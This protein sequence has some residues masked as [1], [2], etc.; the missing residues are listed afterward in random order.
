VAESE[1]IIFHVFDACA[2]L[3]CVTLVG[4]HCRGWLSPQSRSIAC[5]FVA[6]LLCLLIGLGAPSRRRVLLNLPEL[7]E[8]EAE[9]EACDEGTAALWTGLLFVV[10]GLLDEHISAAS[11]LLLGQVLGFQHLALDFL[12]PRPECGARAG[13]GGVLLGLRPVWA[14]ALLLWALAGVLAVGRLRLDEAR[15]QEELVAAY[16]EA[17]SNGI[18]SCLR[19]EGGETNFTQTRLERLFQ[20]I[21]HECRDF[22]KLLVAMDKARRKK[23]W[24]MQGECGRFWSSAWLRLSAHLGDVLVRCGETLQHKEDNFLEAAE[25]D[26]DGF[27]QD[28]AGWLEQSVMLQD[29]RRN[30]GRNSTRNSRGSLESGASFRSCD[31]Q[32]HS[33]NAGFRLEYRVGEWDF[34]ALR[35]EEE[36]HHVLQL[37]GFDLLKGFVALPRVPLGAFLE[38]LEEQY[39]ASNPYHSHVHGA[40][41]TSA[42]FF[43][44]RTSQMWEFAELSDSARVAMLLAALGH[45]VGHGGRNNLFLIGSGDVLALNYNDRSVLENYHAATLS[46]LLKQEHGEST[47]RGLLLDGFTFADQTKA[48]QLMLMLILS[49]DS[50]KHLE[51]LS[52][53]RV[54]LGAEA[55]NPLGDTSD[56]QQALSMLFRAAD[57]GHSAK[58][59]RLHENWSRRVV[60]EF[61]AQ[62]DEERRL[63]L[64]VSPL[65]DREGFVL[66]TAQVG[67]LQYIALPTWKELVR[68]EQAV[69]SLVRPATPASAKGL[70]DAKPHFSLAVTRVVGPGR[71]SP[72]KDCLGEDT[73]ASRVS[74][75]SFDDGTGNNFSS[76]CS[77]RRHF[78]GLPNVLVSCSE[79]GQASR[80]PPKPRQS[81]LRGGLRDGLRDRSRSPSPSP[82]PVCERLHI[83]DT[84]LAQCESNCQTWK[85][86]V[87]VDGVDE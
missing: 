18:E 10:V 25:A 19:A 71:E 85:N 84:C 11:Y 34:D 40:D 50:Q 56:M 53:F 87:V 44:V 75:R 64:P 23:P 66:A 47:E 63:G 82:M 54:R 48:R 37:I 55:F 74:R 4:L 61:H 15:K 26:Q 13:P 76:E 6:W 3:I 41:M 22:H 28:V 42:F 62:G 59:W 20:E 24:L 52:A 30:M 65:C 8:A 73:I 38:R 5:A 78:E 36:Q 32:F 35:T 81:G 79:A 57:I 7:P 58:E 60:Q 39:V 9:A 45:D 17:H 1:H 43:L 31:R 51:E 33:M 69:Q 86:Q 72:R 12:L 14:S 70:R 68:L 27:A 67:F 2:M 46:R 49:T 29:D 77:D 80:A 21:E 16:I 83:S